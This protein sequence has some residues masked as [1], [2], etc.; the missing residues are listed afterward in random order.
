[1]NGETA[2]GPALDRVGGWRLGGVLGHGA[3]GEVRRAIDAEGRPAAVKLVRLEDGEAGVER[4]RRFRA[5]A[6]VAARL[7]H[8]DIVRI[9]GSGIDGTQ[10]WLAMELLAGTDLARYTRPARLLPEAVVVQVMQRAARALAHAHRLGIVHRD[11]KPANVIVDWAR[12]RV[13][14]TDFGL[15]SLAGGERT[16]TG[17]VL[18]SPAYMAPEQLAGAP[19]GP[20]GDLYSL[21]VMM[22]QLLTGRLPYEG[23]TLGELLRRVAQE[24]P[25]RLADLRPDLPPAWG[26]LLESLLA[27]TPAQR[28]PDA[29]TLADR[30][31][32]LPLIGPEPVPGPKSRG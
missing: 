28:V 5:E 31:G 26:W 11:V 2:P 1:M 21:G 16:Q 27:K 25:P 17:V 32:Q 7:V 13:T 15:A 6:A 12:R 29:D 10:G 14:L 9:Y 3:V 8:P 18:G 4:R 30:L 22:F 19:A 20:S 23:D 24:P